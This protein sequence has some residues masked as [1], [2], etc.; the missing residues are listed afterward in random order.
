M[1]KLLYFLE[2][3]SRL[4]R[5][6]FNLFVACSLSGCTSYVH[7]SDTMQNKNIKEESLK[8]Q[9]TDLSKIISNEER[10]N[11]IPVGMLSSIAEVESKQNPYAINANRKSHNFK[12]QN[13]AVK[14]V[15][16]LSA[17]G[18]KNIS[19]GC[20]QLHYATHLKNFESI[21]DMLTPQ[22]NIS[23]AAKLLKGLYNKYGSWEKAIKMYHTSKPKYHNTYYKKVMKNY[24]KQNK[25]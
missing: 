6:L 5:V 22:K 21:N 24:N 12:N 19:V 8:K 13:D 23:Y 1:Y 9:E 4:N 16:Q 2:I 11:G 18:V 15:K 14:Y 7:T 10:N 3:T 17:K 25:V 20:C